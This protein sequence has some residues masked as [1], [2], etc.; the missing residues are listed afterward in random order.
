MRRFGNIYI[1]NSISPLTLAVFIAVE[2]LVDGMMLETPYSAI[3][4]FFG[5]A[6]MRHTLIWSLIG[7][8]KRLEEVKLLLVIFNYIYYLCV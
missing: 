2:S 5:E 1:V 6:E 3:L 8:P 7:N 4:I